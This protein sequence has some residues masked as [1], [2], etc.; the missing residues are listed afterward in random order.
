MKIYDLFTDEDDLTYFIEFCPNYRLGSFSKVYFIEDTDLVIKETE[1][2]A[3]LEFINFINTYHESK[4]LPKIYDNIVINGCNYLLMD[5]LYHTDLN[6][7]EVAEMV[8]WWEKDTNVWV[9]E[10]DTLDKVLYD[11]EEWYSQSCIHLEWDLRDTNIMQ[12]KLGNLVITDP[13][14]SNL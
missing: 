10:S 2:E 6:N 4:H 5:K 7:Q 9:G 11:L 1:D 12:D 13:W 14:C 3:Y 8:G